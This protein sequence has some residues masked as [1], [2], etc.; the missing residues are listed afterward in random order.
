MKRRTRNERS[1]KPKNSRV[2]FDDRPFNFATDDFVI[3]SPQL[4]VYFPH[5][6]HVQVFLA[7]SMLDL[8]RYAGRTS[9]TLLRNGC[10]RTVFGF[11]TFVTK[12]A[13]RNRQGSV[14]MCGFSNP[15]CY[16]RLRCVWTSDRF[17]G[18]NYV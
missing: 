11:N 16:E 8:S 15:F 18:C 2:P 4:T 13:S 14:D 10:E 12:L 3:T 9:G 6:R 17:N 7:N 5:L 1:S